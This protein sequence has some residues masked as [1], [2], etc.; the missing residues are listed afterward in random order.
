M[1]KQSKS[2]VGMTAHKMN[3][4]MSDMNILFLWNYYGFAM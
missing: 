2:G 4:W 1:V 3:V